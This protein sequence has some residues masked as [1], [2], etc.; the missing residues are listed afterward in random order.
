MDAQSGG[1]RLSRLPPAFSG[2]TL[3]LD[4]AFP[5]SGWRVGHGR[6]L[7]RLIEVIAIAA[8]LAVVASA[9]RAYAATYH[10][11]DGASLQA[12]VASANASS[13]SSTIELGSGAFLPASTLTISRDVTIIGPS[14]APGAKL[15]GSAV[16]PFPSDLLLVEAHAKLTLWNVEL[17]AGGGD[18]SAAIDDY[19][20][21]DLESST[22]AG[23]DGPGLWVQ[24][25]GAATVRNATI[26]DGL[27]FGVVDDGT[28][29]LFNSTVASNKDGGLE[30]RGTLNLTNTIV[31]EN[32]GSGDCEGRATSSDHSL[33]SDSSC[34]VGALSRTDP[35]L[36]SLTANGGPT[37]TQTLA[38][39]SPAIGAGDDSKC[40]A[41]D[42]RHFARPA[43]RCDLGAYETGAVPGSAQPA[44]SGGGAGSGLSSG[45]AA[46][47]LGVSAHGALRGAR[48]SRITFTVRARAGHSSA[49]FLYSDGVHR[50][51]LRK[52]TVRSLAIDLRRGVATLRGSGVETPRG[53]RVSVT[54]VL[55]SHGGHR[56][57]RI[58]LSGGYYKS[59]PLLSGSITFVRSAG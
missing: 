33:D 55:V 54:V 6:C 42:E 49:T 37:E 35:E 17:T 7:F 57:L 29:S 5:G 18:G 52:L 34:G 39:G 32:T 16:A 12:A 46:A 25:G 10:A 15:A 22:V 9:E 20:A 45:G 24:P 38:A 23:N 1:S 43:G 28:A 41:E 31:A 58:S 13:G 48:H 36:G 8:A 26:S 56:S 30:N 50:V 40:P 21:L 47:A 14:S 59:G 44:P 53:R 3:G 11:E 4:A 27:T 19:G 51:A 2:K